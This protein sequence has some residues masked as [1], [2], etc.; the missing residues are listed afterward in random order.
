MDYLNIF[1]PYTFI[2]LMGFFPLSWTVFFIDD[3]RV[4]RQRLTLFILTNKT[5]IVRA[6]RNT[7]QQMIEPYLDC[8]VGIQYGRKETEF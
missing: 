1:D 5:K 2:I 8:T 6:Q 4:G 7:Q 3:K